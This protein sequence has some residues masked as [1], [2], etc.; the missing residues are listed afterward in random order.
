MLFESVYVS[1][2]Q[3]LAFGCC[4]FW[5]YQSCAEAGTAAL[6]QD[7]MWFTESVKCSGNNLDEKHDT[8]KKEED[9][10]YLFGF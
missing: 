5:S 6:L 2:F 4:S 1:D 9:I 3:R 7:T 8:V 10:F